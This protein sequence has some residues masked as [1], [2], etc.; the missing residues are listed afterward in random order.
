MRADRNL[1]RRVS[2]LAEVAIVAGLAA[3]LLAGIPLAA[4]R[5]NYDDVRACRARDFATSLGTS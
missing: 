2:D 1:L 3:A 5:R 4:A